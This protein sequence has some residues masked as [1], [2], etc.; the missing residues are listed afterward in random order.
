M[1]VVKKNKYNAKKT[2]YNGLIYDSKKE[3]MRAEQLDKMLANGD[4]I[5]I[6]RQVPIRC[7]VNSKLI[8]KLILDFIYTLPDGTIIHEDVK[9][10]KPLPIFNLKCKLIKALHGIDIIIF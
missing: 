6:Q 8:C 9:G 7:E 1:T 5:N 3:A 2:E 4:I 10:M